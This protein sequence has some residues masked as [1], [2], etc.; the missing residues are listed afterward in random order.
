MSIGGRERFI[1]FEEEY[2]RLKRIP[3][4]VK[5]VG[6]KQGRKLWFT[7]FLNQPCT[8]IGNLVKPIVCSSYLFT[9][10]G[11]T[12][13]LKLP[14]LEVVEINEGQEGLAAIPEI[15]GY[16][17]NCGWKPRSHGPRI[18]RQEIPSHSSSPRYSGDFVS[19]PIPHKLRE[20]ATRLVRYEPNRL[21]FDVSA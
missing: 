18:P 15:E 4:L 3:D 20:I 14:D 12:P 5:A 1:N 8:R 9:L 6:T 13:G 21:Y 7:G 16:Y 10:E 11:K 19:I 17:L 2:R